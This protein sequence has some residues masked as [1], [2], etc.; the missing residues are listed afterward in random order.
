MALRDRVARGASLPALLLG[1]GL[2]PSTG[3]A[4]EAPVVLADANTVSELLVTGK[5]P[6]ITASS[7][8]PAGAHIERRAIEEMPTGLRV[9]EIVKRLPGVTSGGGPGEDKDVRILGLDKEFSRTTVNGLSVPDGGEKRELTLD[10]LP[11]LFVGS[12]DLQRAKTADQEADGIAGRI[13]I[14]TR[15]IPSHRMIDVLAGYGRADKDGAESETVG[16]VAGGPLSSRWGAQGAVSWSRLP[17]IKD[18]RTE[19]GGVVTQVETERKPADATD[20]LGDFQ[21][22]VG[23]TLLRVQPAYYRVEESKDKTV[24]KF[25]AAGA[26]NGSE[27]ET[28]DKIKETTSLSL[29]GKTRRDTP[30]WLNDQVELDARVAFARNTEDKD[31][32]KN[33]YSAAGV[34]QT[35]KRAT[36]TEAKEDQS[37][38]FDMNARFGDADDGHVPRVGLLVRERDRS[39]NKAATTGGV[40]STAAK[41]TYDLNERLL[42]AYV[43]DE[44]HVNSAWTVTPGLRVE[45]MRLESKSGAGDIGNSTDTEVLPSVATKFEWTP[46]LVISGGLARAINRPKFDE[47]APFE[48]VTSSKV[49]LGNPDLEPARAWSLDVDAR[50]S[51]G[52]WTM[53]VG[54]FYRDIEG[55]I[56]TIT[57]GQ[58]PYGATTI[59]VE[60]TVNVGDGWTQGLIVEQRLDLGFTGAPVLKGISVTANGT[61]TRSALH[62][63]NGA[64][65]RFKEQPPFYGNL[66]FNWGNTPTGTAVSVA[67]THTSRLTNEENG[68]RRASEVMTDVQLSQRLRSNLKLVISGE[69]LGGTERVTRKTSG[70]TTYE[71]GARIWRVSLV[72]RF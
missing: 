2:L 65:R 57:V 14:K 67:L 47:L 45:T 69:N 42:A 34:E 28:E 46:N 68:D 58:R 15:N 26:A 64:T 27:P 70:E 12:V 3:M 7:L 13:D 66:I 36:E 51:R 32:V 21:Y 59:P 37:V 20:V 35:A 9:E 29:S 31:K 16:I 52:P 48:T 4:A 40:V 22:T 25:T 38:Q 24:A 6:L 8:S 60:Q 72:G 17:S 54:G 23:D 18:K 62:P 53:S 11:S 10:R 61:W 43:L 50:Y 1:L 49:T 56:E 41:D 5:S 19:K 33:V 30:S 63:A 39:K 71:S 44:V 55:V